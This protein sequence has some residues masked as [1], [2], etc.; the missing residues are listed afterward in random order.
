MV[1]PFA[2]RI[3]ALPIS[4]ALGPH[5]PGT[6]YTAATSTDAPSLN[7]AKPWALTLNEAVHTLPQALMPPSIHLLKPGLYPHWPEALY[8]AA[9]CT[10]APSL[11]LTKALTCNEAVHTPA[12][13]I[14]APLLPGI[15]RFV[16]L[17]DIHSLQ[18][19][20]SLLQTCRCLQGHRLASMES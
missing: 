14:D 1:H 7:L 13:G 3:L 6:V 15:L 10:D 20:P 5:W 16:V 17:R 12:A 2:T 9:S 11:H 18:C 4:E 19:V 8:T